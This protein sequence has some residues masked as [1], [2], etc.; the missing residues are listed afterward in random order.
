MENKIQKLITKVLNDTKDDH[1]ASDGEIEC[2]ALL[3][4]LIVNSNKHTRVEFFRANI[5]LVEKVKKIIDKKI[6]K[7][8]KK[9][10]GKD[11]SQVRKGPI[12]N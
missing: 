2:L 4:S 11:K 7:T 5:G 10:A 1:R 12:I 6:L 3:I 8:V 9:L